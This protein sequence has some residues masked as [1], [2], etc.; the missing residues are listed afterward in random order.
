MSDEYTEVETVSWA[1]RKGNSF[2]WLFVGILLFFGSFFLLYWNEGKTDFSEVA[3]TAIDIA[4]TATPS[5]AIGKLVFTTGILTSNQ[6]LGD[7]LFLKQGNYIALDRKVE[8]YAWSEETKTDTKKNLGG[9]ETK[10][11]TYTYT[12]GWT[13]A[14]KSSTSFKHRE[15]HDNPKKAVINLTRKVSAAKVGVYNLDIAS[16]ELPTLSNLQ[17]SHRNAILTQGA[18][19]VG[20]YLYQGNGSV[21]NPQVGDLQIRYSVLYSNIRVAVLGKLEGN[22]RITPYI[23]KINNKLY[24]NKLYRIFIGTKDQAI[25]TLKT[26]YSVWT[27]VLRLLGFILMWTGL[28]M[29]FEPLNVFLDLIPAVGFIS[30]RLSNSATFLVSF[31]LSTV[32]ILGSILIHNMVVLLITVAISFGLVIALLSKK[33]RKN[34]RFA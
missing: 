3:R 13:E 25:S 7:S 34:N 23:H 6:L 2:M 21:N 22:N 16:I 28:S 18:L 9:S 8:M 5:T 14:P 24:K 12:K 29:F 32:T 15:Q 4:S 11:T 17:L 1:T 19:L 26:E 31:A 10:N 33:R 27:W 30:R 20:D